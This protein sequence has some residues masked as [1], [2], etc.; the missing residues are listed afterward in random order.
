MKYTLSAPAVIH[1]KSHVAVVYMFAHA[2]WHVIINVQLFVEVKST[3]LNAEVRNRHTH[4]PSTERTTIYK[5]IF[6]KVYEQGVDR[7]NTIHTLVACQ[8]RDAK[9][10]LGRGQSGR[11]TG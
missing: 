11:L 4:S 3:D 7:A 10:P 5:I 1:Q 8:A 9:V 6:L 2:A